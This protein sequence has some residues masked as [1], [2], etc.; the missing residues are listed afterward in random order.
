M[1][2]SGW[3]AQAEGEPEKGASR[4]LPMT[5]SCPSYCSD[6]IRSQDLDAYEVFSSW[7]CTILERGTAVIREPSDASL[8]YD[9]SRIEIRLLRETRS[10]RVSVL[11]F[12]N[13]QCGIW[14]QKGPMKD[15]PHMFV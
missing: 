7:K 14:F 6:C 2:N 1:H 12:T 5:L 9:S 11:T 10:V 8:A 4:R 13:Y 15:T 3:G